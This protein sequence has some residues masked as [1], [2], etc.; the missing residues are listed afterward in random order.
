MNNF[1]KEMHT[2]RKLS[3][4]PRIVVT[5]LPAHRYVYDQLGMVSKD[6]IAPIT[7]YWSMIAMLLS[8][9]YHFSRIFCVKLKELNDE[10]FDLRKH[11][12]RQHELAKTKDDIVFLNA[13]QQE[14]E[15]QLK[16]EIDKFEQLLQIVR[17]KSGRSIKGRLK[18]KSRIALAKQISITSILKRFGKEVKNK[19][20]K[21]PYHDEST[22]SCAI[23]EKQNAYWSYCCNRGG[24]NI[25]LVRALTGCSFIEAIN[26]L[27]PK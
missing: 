5:D 23:Y 2:L 8:D 11:Y 9:K 20:T 18:T 21:C 10:L 16:E 1:S 25:S 22:P 26:K 13:M 6:T 4:N 3:N 17:E 15:L 24:D 19:F 7:E 27:V 14:R 12:N